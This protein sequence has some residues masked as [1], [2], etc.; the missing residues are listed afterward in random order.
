MGITAAHV[1]RKFEADAADGAVKLQVMNALIDN[2]SIVAI[3]DRL[4]IATIRLDEDILQRLGKPST[5]VQIWRGRSPSEERGIMLAGY[6]GIER[7]TRHPRDV[8]FGLFTA[9]GISRRVTDE[10]ITWVP[11]R[12]NNVGRIPMPPPGYNT[13]GISGG[14]VIGWFESP[15]SIA[16][17]G[18]VAIVSQASAELENIVCKRAD[19]IRNDG[20]I[21]DLA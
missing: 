19:F 4:D 21:R 1:V 16:T 15:N 17:Y 5:P 6:P 13:G 8:N 18:L 3:S 12:E 11:D 2:I 20:T 9:L 14:P 7:V 10:Q